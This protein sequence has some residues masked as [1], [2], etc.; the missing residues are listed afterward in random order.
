MGGVRWFMPAQRLSI[1]GIGMLSFETTVTLSVGYEVARASPDSIAKVG[2]DTSA[3]GNSFTLS[4]SH[5]LVTG[6]DR[7]VVICVGIENG[8]TVDVDSVTYGG[9]ACNKAVDW[10]T[11]TSG[12]RYLTEIWYILETDLPSDGP[13]T[14]LITASGTASSLEH[15]GYCAEYTGIE[16][17]VPEATDGNNTISSPITNTISPSDGAWVISAVGCGNAGSFSHGEGQVEVLDFGDAAM[18][19][20]RFLHRGTTRTASRAHI[21]DSCRG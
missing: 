16:Q 11:G 18:S 21:P 8:D 7:V 9:V 4:F 13:N 20:C 12:F 2:T 14:V 10:I 19:S 5:T 17:V 1:E 15:N 6:S 3:T